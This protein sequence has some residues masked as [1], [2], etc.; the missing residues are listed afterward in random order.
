MPDGHAG[1]RALAD[2]GIDVR[3]VR[4]HQDV[5]FRDGDVHF[6]RV[7]A[8]FDGVFKSGDRVLGAHRA[9]AAMSMDQG[10]AGGHS[11]TLRQEFFAGRGFFC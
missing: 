1:M 2:F 8:D 10:A 3:I 5:V 4:D 6:E 11:R 7:G 9:G